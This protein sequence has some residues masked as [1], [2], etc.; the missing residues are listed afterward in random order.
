MKR[1]DFLHLF[2]GYSERPDAIPDAIV[3]ATLR[4]LKIPRT[5]EVDR[6]T[7]EHLQQVFWLA[8]RGLEPAE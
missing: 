8:S 3:S 4:D 1:T 6:R 2:R 7:R 5:P